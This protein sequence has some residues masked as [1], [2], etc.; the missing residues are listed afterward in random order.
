M[1][2]ISITDTEKKHNNILLTTLSLVFGFMLN[3][4]FPQFFQG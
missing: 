2:L 3:L 4:L 1:I